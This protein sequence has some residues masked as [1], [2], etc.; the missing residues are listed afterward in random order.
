MKKLVLIE[1]EDSRSPNGAWKHLCEKQNFDPVKC[2][3]VGWLIF[4]NK[5]I[6]VVAPNMGDIYDA[7]NIQY[8]GE[9]IIPT[10]CILKITF[11]KTT[12]NHTI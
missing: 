12:Y 3:S 11:L 8:S 7:S 10:S 5:K 4:S 9:I 6:K 1:W 2:K